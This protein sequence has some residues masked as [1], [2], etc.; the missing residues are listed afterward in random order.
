[1]NG[2]GELGARAVW[3]WSLDS[4]SQEWCVVR[5][6]LATR[7]EI[8]DPGMLARNYEREIAPAPQL[9]YLLWDTQSLEETQ[10]YKERDGNQET[11]GDT[12]P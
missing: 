11:S 5:V 8:G 10:R 1:M 2:D 7:W 3:P 4:T 12:I 6:G 9:G